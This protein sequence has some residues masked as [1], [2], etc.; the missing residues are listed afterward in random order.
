[1]YLGRIIH[2]RVDTP[3]E[4]VLEKLGVGGFTTS[5]SSKVDIEESGT[6]DLATSYVQS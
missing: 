1:M 6:R 2:V 5:Q 3:F 4:D